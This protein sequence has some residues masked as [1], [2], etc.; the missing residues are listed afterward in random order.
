MQF[1]GGLT[2]FKILHYS[3][4]DIAP[5]IL[6]GKYLGDFAL[7]SYT[8]AVQ[9]LTLPVVM[10]IMPIGPVAVSMLSKVIDDPIRVRRAHLQMVDRVAFLSI[11]TVAVLIAASDWIVAI[12]LGSQWTA[13]ADVFAILALATLPMILG[14]TSDWLFMA[15]GKARTLF[16]YGVLRVIFVIA[17]VIV[18]FRGGL[19]GVAWG[20]ALSRLLLVFPLQFFVT[21]RHTPVSS[22]DMIKTILPSTLLGVAIVA[23]ARTMRAFV[24]EMHNA[25]IGLA[26]TTALSLAIIGMAVIVFPPLRRS[27]YGLAELF[28]L[29]KAA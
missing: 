13:T 8:R 15:Y 19:I 10:I 16:N 21:G 11:P 5:N 14:D 9:I 7:G 25:F 29:R 24:P 28:K 22:T 4:R 20:I 1:G 27:S 12:M 2:A 23:A 6:I 18:G 3:A 17:G 26:A